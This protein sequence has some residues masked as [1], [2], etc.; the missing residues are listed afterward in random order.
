LSLDGKVAN[1]FY[2]IVSLATLL[3]LTPNGLLIDSV[4]IHTEIRA[5][6]AELERT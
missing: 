1:P 2:L 5:T 4:E 3:A 6:L